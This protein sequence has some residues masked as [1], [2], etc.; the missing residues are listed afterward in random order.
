M[1]NFVFFSSI[2]SDIAKMDKKYIQIN[3]NYGNIQDLNTN[4]GIVKYY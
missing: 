4:V 3:L 1:Q 2:Y